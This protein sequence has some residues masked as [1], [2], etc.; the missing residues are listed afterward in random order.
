MNRPTETVYNLYDLPMIHRRRFHRN[1]RGVAVPEAAFCIPIVLVLVFGT[2]EV[3]QYIFIKE[4]ASICAYEGCRVGVKRRATAEDAQEATEELLRSF[5][6]NDAD[7]EVNVSPSNFNSLD[8]LDPIRVE[9]E[10]QLTGA[11]FVIGNAVQNSSIT[12]SVQMVREFDD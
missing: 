5:G 10:I 12:S 7:F 11:A 3:C 4:R 2:L 1:R 6:F 9:V 8:A